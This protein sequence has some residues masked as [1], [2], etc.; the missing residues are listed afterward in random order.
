MTPKKVVSSKRTHKSKK[1]TRKAR[2]TPSPL[3]DNPRY[4]YQQLMADRYAGIA[5]GAHLSKLRSSAIEDTSDMFPA[6][7]TATTPAT[8]GGNNWVP[9]GPKAIAGGQSLGGSRIVVTGRV[10]GVAQDP[11]NPGI[12]YVAA[13]RGGIWKTTDGGVTWT[14]MSDNEVSLA[15]GALAIAPSNPQ[16][17]YAGTGEGNILYYATTFPLNSINE[18]YSGSGILQSS[19]GGATWNTQGA[20]IFAGACFYRIAVHPTDASTAFAASSK[21]LYRTTNAGGNWTQL[22][23]GLPAIDPTVI[24]A[25]DVMIDPTTPD[26]A[27]V[28][29]W[30]SGIYKTTNANAANPAWTQVTNGLPSASLGRISTAI[31]PTSPQTL[32]ALIA[33]IGDAFNSFYVSTNGGAAWT[34]ISAAAAVVQVYGAY[35]SNVS[36]DISTP[37]VVY[38]SGLSLYKAVNRGGTWT[39]T[40]IG[41]AIHA[42]NHAFASHPT[43]H[44]VIYAGNDGGIYKSSDGGATWDDTFNEGL[45]LTQFEFIDQHPTSDAVIIGGT[46]DNGT[47]QFRNSPAFYHSADGD[48]GS[49]GVDRT[50][51]RN[52]LHTYFGANIE[53]STQGGAFTSWANVS[54]GLSGSSLFYPP[55]AFDPTNSQN[56]AF[57]MNGVFLDSAQGSGGWPISVAL[58]GISGDVSAISFVNSSLIYACSTSGQVYRLSKSGASWTASAIHAAPLPTGYWIWGISTLSADVNTVIVV[59]AGFGIHH[60]W[61]GSVASSG[62]NA[63]WADISGTGANHVPDIP[64]NALT[65]DPISA[66]TFY[67]GTDIGVF[68]TT[69]A[70]VNWQQFSDGLPNTA[71]YDLALHAQTRLLRA[72]THGR[73]IWERK[74]DVVATPNVDIYLRDHLLA[75]GR[76]LPTPSPVAAN[77]D[78]PLQSVA[79]GDPLYWWMCADA[80]VDS[81]AAT[82]HAYQFAVSAV[83]Y[84]VFETKLAHTN[85]QLGVTNRVYVQVHNRGIQP[86]TNVTVK[87]LFAAAAPVLPPLPP[88]FWTAFPGNGTTAVWMPIG[89]AQTIPSIS[90]TRPEILEW[91][92]VPPA[93]QAPHTCLLVVMDCAS[94]PIPATNKVLDVATL[95]TTEKRVGL[96]NLHL[97]PALP[98][99]LWFGLKISGLAKAADVLRVV[100]AP[101]G[102]SAGLL[103]PNTVA[104]RVKTVGLSASKLG[105]P[106][107]AALQRT[108]GANFKLYDPAQFRTLASGSAGAMITG[109]AA[110]VK[111][112]DLMLT[113]AAQS[114][115]AQRGSVTVVAESGGKA[116]GGNTFV[117]IP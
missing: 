18:S 15:I 116:V 93:G 99:P 67:I 54:G 29:F 106:Q 87:I 73:G 41:Q 115:K 53:R 103:M 58:P 94:D 10:A 51:P 75:T 23:N 65:I 47:E 112:F 69:D 27:Y 88:D 107:I 96:K 32:Y 66:S 7:E 5:R 91:D 28:A 85:P 77:F 2:A 55:L 21:G 22:T 89:A 83:D 44:L 57:G 48:G 95:V 36:V 33:N 49:A 61:R 84:L 30:G 43:D 3:Q 17:L 79:L 92:W 14:P 4:R 20:N 102:W 104:S 9:L 101:P 100:G 71:V 81:P 86:A 68:R 8:V 42:D 80:K 35:T 11:T 6:H 25:T 37:D 70:G 19:D 52:M 60:V 78:D 90:P 59:F 72:A 111:D 40:D 62:T 16:V 38:I 45:T 26:T 63:T 113:F 76:I 64:V 117:L 34:S 24:A 1:P 108:L 46:Q 82:T 56:V 114:K 12:I 31:S 110:A 39:V 105:K 97:I 98:A 50:T 74:L 13:A 109:F